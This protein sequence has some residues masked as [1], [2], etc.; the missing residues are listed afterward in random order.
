MPDSQNSPKPALKLTT[1]S[2][3]NTALLLSKSS[4]QTVSAET[5]REDI[6]AGA[7]TNPDG[8][9]NLIHYAAWLAREVEA[10]GD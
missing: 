2:V 8:T 4:G 1:L 7:P 6:E 10:R 5:I 3:E 9:V